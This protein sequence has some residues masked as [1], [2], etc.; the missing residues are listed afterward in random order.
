MAGQDRSASQSPKQKENDV[1]D[2]YSNIHELGDPTLSPQLPQR[3]QAFQKRE[4]SLTTGSHKVANDDDG[5]DYKNIDELV[6]PAPDDNPQE[7]HIYQHYDLEGARSGDD[8]HS[9]GEIAGS[10]QPLPPDLRPDER[11]VSATKPINVQ[12]KRSFSKYITHLYV[13]SHLILF[14]ILGT[15]ARLGLQAL[16]RYPGAPVAFSELW[17]N[18]GGCAILGYL[19]EERWL[20]RKEWEIATREAH[21][22]DERRVLTINQNLTEKASDDTSL[23]AA[24]QAHQIAKKSIPLYIGLAVGFCG[25]FTSF[26]SFLR[27]VFLALSN[28]LDAGVYAT[29]SQTTPAKLPRNPGDSVMAVIA[30]L[31]VEIAVSLSCL[32]L[33]AH[34]AMSLQ[35]LTSRIP[36]T[37]ARRFVDPLIVPIAWVTWFGAIAMAVWPPEQCKSWRGDVLFAI[38]LSPLGCLARFHAS[39]RLNGLVKWFP[40]GTFIVNVGGTIVLGA[41]WDLQHASLHDRAKGGG[42][43]GSQILQGVQ[44]GFCGCLTTVSTWI[45]ELKGLRRKHAYFYGVMSVG[46]SFSS[47]VVI[48]GTFLWAQEKSVVQS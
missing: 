3:D 38:V 17:A 35:P 2:E 30:V 7:G 40:M 28:D 39:L 29:L 47:L 19:S 27:D 23:L 21:C 33:G 15:L 10:A 11:S 34:A 18:A 37:D 44:D 12:V 31:L 4:S 1:P 46:I 16:T 6:G 24:K 41:C 20:F 32:E 14:S 45:L 5:D 42:I 48:M 26:S 8:E 13:T 9:N 43:A 22:S 36:S 25:S